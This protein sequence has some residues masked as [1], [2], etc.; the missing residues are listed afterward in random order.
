MDTSSQRRATATAADVQSGLT[1]HSSFSGK[2][3]EDHAGQEQHSEG[4]HRE[5]CLLSDNSKLTVTAFNSTHGEF[6]ATNPQTITILNTSPSK[7]FRP[8][9]DQFIAA[10]F[11][12][13]SFG[14]S[15]QTIAEMNLGNHIMIM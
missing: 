14:K 7:H 5:H 1:L 12:N 8:I 4:D 2:A 13:E 15:G 9:L 11:S 6:A 10:G 3:R